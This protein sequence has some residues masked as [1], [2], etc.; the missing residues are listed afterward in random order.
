MARRDFAP[1]TPELISRDRA[2]SRDFYTR[3]LGFDVRYEREGF[4]YLDREGAQI[5]LEQ[6]D[7]NWVT[8]P[9]EPPF[10]RGINLQ[11]EAADVRAVHRVVTEAAWPVF[12]DLEEAWYRADTVERGHLE[13]LIQDPDGYL[14]RFFQDLGTRP[15]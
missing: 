14:L 3:I 11:I 15:A 9:L 7:D 5:M 2:V 6:L 12:R 13:F 8:G 10:G 1:L 4:V